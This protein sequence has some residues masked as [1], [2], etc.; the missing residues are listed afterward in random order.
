MT[1]GS[2]LEIYTTYFGWAF[3]DLLWELLAGIGLIYIPF[4]TA[5]YQSWKAPVVSAQRSHPAALVSLKQM[6]WSIYPMLLMVL[7]AGVPLITLDLVDLKYPTLICEGETTEEV[8][9]GVTGTTFD[10]MDDFVA[11]DGAVSVPIIWYLGMAIMN[12]TSRAAIASVPCF[13][14]ISG[15]DYKLRNL[16]LDHEPLRKEFTRFANECFVPVK[17]KFMEAMGDGQWG[18]YTQEAFADGIGEDKWDESDPFYIGSDFYFETEGF[19]KPCVEPDTCGLHRYRAKTPVDGYG[20][21]VSRDQDYTVAEVTEGVGRPYC[22]EWWDNGINTGLRDRLVAG[23][24]DV[25]P[26]YLGTV[27][28]KVTEVLAW[29]AEFIG[30]EAYTEDDVKDIIIKRLLSSEQV[31]FTG[32]EG[33]V[34]TTTIS[35]GDASTLTNLGGAAAGEILA[36]GSGSVV[37]VPVLKAGAIAGVTGGIALAKQLAGF[38]MSMYVAKKA[39]PMVQAIILMLLYIVLPI[40]MLASGFSFTAMFSMLLTWFVLRFFTVL[41]VMG[42][43][44]DAQL[45]AMMFPDA[46]VVGSVLSL[47]INRFILDIVLSVF[48]LV[49]PVILLGV[50]AMTG[51]NI[52]FTEG[53]GFMNPVRAAGASTSKGNFGKGK[54][55]K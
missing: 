32:I 14:D 11:V 1:V 49:G 45:Y 4:I 15:L 12:G 38:Y 13:E 27:E 28:E 7:F 8:S 6:Q 35:S 33:L 22:D 31:D 44:L 46:T 10:K 5:V 17:S 20:Y 52:A 54:G 30:S 2:V 40:Y 51:T 26:T 36:L 21:D 37:T 48:F 42:S 47:N 18:E 41:W 53:S 23:A 43:L 55:K 19:Y 24:K 16:T 9:G 29:A 39:A 25:E 50:V 3:Y 34:E